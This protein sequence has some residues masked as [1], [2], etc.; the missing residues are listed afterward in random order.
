MGANNSSTATSSEMVGMR[1]LAAICSTVSVVATTN[2]TLG[3]CRRLRVRLHRDHV[4]HC[5]QRVVDSW[6]AAIGIAQCG[7]I[8]TAT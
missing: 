6:R 3:G 2:S 4:A 1:H 7:S 8:F 5:G